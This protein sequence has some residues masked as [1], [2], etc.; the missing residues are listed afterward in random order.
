MDFN[1]PIGIE[2][3]GPYQVNSRREIIHLLRGIKED[4]QLVRMIFNNGSEAIVTS[5]LDIDEAGNRVIVD[6]APEQQQ[7]DRIVSSDNIS[8]ESTLNRIRIMFFSSRL[9][10]C[11]HA[12]KPALRM[13]LPSNIIRLQRREFYRVR[14]P[15]TPIRIPVMTNE[16]LSEVTA[17]LRD[18]S[19]GG[20]SIMD[21]R[22]ALDNTVGRVYEDCRITLSDNSIIITSIEIKNS[23]ELLLENDM[24]A[25]VLGFQFY[26]IPSQTK[27][28]LQRYISKV[29]REQNA[30]T[31]N[32]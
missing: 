10:N 19:A 24:K 5:I 18:I 26:A 13:A 14:T 17:Y 29:E 31:T 6:C 25:R 23:Y 20:I 27:M 22:M 1:P 3:L 30:K 16:G 2:D 12:G 8:F 11:H 15:R 9:V 7:N 21:E 4:K 32:R 28:L